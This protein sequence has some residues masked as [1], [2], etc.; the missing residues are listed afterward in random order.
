[1]AI[2]PFF[3]FPFAGNINCPDGLATCGVSEVVPT[4]T[5]LP[6]PLFPLPPDPIPA[7][8]TAALARVAL[9]GGG[10]GVEAGFAVLGG[11]NGGSDEFDVRKNGFPYVARYRKSIPKPFCNSGC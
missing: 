10:A 7:A 6:P 9:Y 5:T 11:G 2:A 3:K 8:A 4:P 1:M